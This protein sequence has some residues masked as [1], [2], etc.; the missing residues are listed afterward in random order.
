MKLA[1]CSYIV[2]INSI[3]KKT[4]NIS[5]TPN[6]IDKTIET[7]LITPKYLLSFILGIYRITEKAIIGIVNMHRKNNNDSTDANIILRVAPIIISALG[8]Y[9]A[10]STF[11]FSFFI[12]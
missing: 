11:S 3:E 7:I 9:L 10:I 4:D 8:E 5:I 2:W 6:T 12:I 1:K